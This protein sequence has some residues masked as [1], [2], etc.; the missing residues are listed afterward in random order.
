MS[1]ARYE[2]GSLFLTAICIRIGLLSSNIFSIF[3]LTVLHIHR[4]MQQMEDLLN[5][6][7]CGHFLIE[8]ATMC[9]SAFSVVTVQNNNCFVLLHYKLVYDEM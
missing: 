4:F 1:E 2:F 5:I 3:C 7:L 8:L 9:F 6:G